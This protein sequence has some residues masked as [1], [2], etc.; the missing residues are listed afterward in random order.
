MIF[1]FDWGHET[2]KVIGPLSQEDL[3]IKVPSEFV[4]LVLVK[5]WFRAFFIPTIPTSKRY[6]LIASENNQRI[7]ISKTDFEKL[8]PIAEL[9][10]MVL[11][12][13]ISE[14]EYNAL[15]VNMTIF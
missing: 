1:I 3:Y 5:S 9:N 2:R 15:R 6:F 8:R 4:D 10:N 14:E 11:K 12:E 13:E 7:E